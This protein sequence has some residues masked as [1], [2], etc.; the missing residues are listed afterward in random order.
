V[1]AE[2]EPIDAV[3]PV[4]GV[5]MNPANGGLY[6]PGQSAEKALGYTPVAFNQAANAIKPASVTLGFGQ[7][8]LALPPKLRADAFNHF[9][10]NYTH[11]D[12]NVVL[13][14]VKA[15]QRTANGELVLRRSVAAVVSE[16]YTA[17][18]DYDLL[19]DLNAA[20]PDGARCRYTQTESRS[21]V[22]ILWPAMSRQL[23]VGDIALIGLHVSNSQT[24]QGAI[25]IVPKVLRVLCL[26]FTTAWGEGADAEVS[27]IHLG[28][29]RR[30][31]AEAMRNA[32]A[33]VEPFVIAFGDAYQNAL[34]AFA[35][36]RGEA[37]SKAV[38]AFELPAKF[39]DTIAVSWDAD[40]TRGAG[41]TLAGLVNAM[42]RAA[43]ELPID[44][45]AAVEQAS[46]RLIRNGWSELE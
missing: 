16:K 5:R 44:R 42:T 22:E 7:T 40:G 11:D 26:N 35:S 20:L 10:A 43:Q 38:K 24:R 3:V 2:Q 13:R 15:P 31:F 25:R 27:V 41:D 29:A 1:R 39:G 37:I 28:E 19:D 12:K 36:T 4:H 14:T 33:V 21:D 8:L 6:G 45:A 46:G 23:N 9:S 17:V 30:K 34:P 18:E 32:L